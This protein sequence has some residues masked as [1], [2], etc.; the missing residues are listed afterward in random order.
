MPAGVSVA[1]PTSGATITDVSGAA[2]GRLPD[3]K[4]K[5]KKDKVRAAWISFI[6]RIVAQILGAVASVVLGV[7]LLQHYREA[8][9]RGESQAPSLPRESRAPRVAPNRDG[10]SLAVLPLANFSGDPRQDH[11]ADGMTEALIADLAQI[12][13]LRVI[14]RTSSMQY[15]GGDKSLRAIADEL[16]VD[17]IVEGAVIKT[18]A[19]VRVTAQLIDAASD[20]HLWAKSY[21]H[22]GGDILA[23]QGQ[24]AAAIARDVK[25]KAKGSAEMARPP[26]P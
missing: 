19:R 9:S 21:D 5:K 8:T 10:V 7:F 15:K 6:G 26:K 4:V 18:G 24:V 25:A 14:S 22:T 13:G 11:F 20:E 1:A 16:D 23:L 12:E 2:P 17:L 3:Q